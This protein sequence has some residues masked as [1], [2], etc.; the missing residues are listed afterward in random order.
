MSKLELGSLIH[1]ALRNSLSEQRKL[2]LH[3]NVSHLLP[4]IQK[5]ANLNVELERWHSGKFH[6]KTRE[7]CEYFVKHAVEIEAEADRISEE[8]WDYAPVSLVPNFNRIQARLAQIQNVETYPKQLRA[9]FNNFRIGLLEQVVGARF[10][11]NN[12]DLG[13]ETERILVQ[14]LQ[15]RL[16]NSVRI[17]RGGHLY[18]YDGSRS[19]QIDIIITPAN[20]LGLCPADTG[21]GK[22]NVMLDQVIAVISVTATLTSASFRDR[23]DALRRLPHFKE[24]ETRYPGL[25]EQF[26]PLSFIIGAECDNLDEL[27]KAWEE[28]GS[29]NTGPNMII[30]LDSGYIRQEVLRF[31]DGPGG[32][33]E[34]HHQLSTS[35]GIY[36]G[37][38]LAW[39][40][41]HV[42]ARNAWLTN[43]QVDWLPPLWQHVRDLERTEVPLY[44][45][46]REPMLLAHKTIHG[47]IRWGRTA[48]SVHNRLFVTTILTRAEGTI[49]ERTL[50]DKTKPCER[51]TIF[52]YE[53]E[54][55]WFRE[56]V[57]AVNGDF[58][59]LE[60]W[61][62][63][64]DRNNH[65]RRIAVFDGRTGEEVTGR[66]TRSLLECA[67]IEQLN[68]VLKTNI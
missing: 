33:T 44:D 14:Y 65:Q 60:E 55:R 7:R 34:E 39:L 5:L 47:V 59:A 38:G 54:P 8:I 50:L 24:K 67:E 27:R 41:M 45:C 40:E 23:A 68:P 25:K 66:V 32:A 1:T 62:E 10:L 37:L 16:G 35:E 13:E 29:P 63:P 6:R 17:L 49:K 12:S 56:N 48:R 31:K 30:A 51:H 11:E 36:A 61:I 19:D 53:F 18:D 21:D 43:Q 52:D 20:A 57:F 4:V 3:R 22:Y 42:V 2:I 9:Q 28:I 46:R 64:R 58:C 15:R 26:W